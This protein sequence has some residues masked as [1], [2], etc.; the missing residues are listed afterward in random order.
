[1]WYRKN[2]GGWERA[3]RL[4]SEHLDHIVGDLDLARGGGG[5]VD[6]AA[7]LR[8]RLALT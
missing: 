7:V 3:A 6:V 2:V 8:E 5:A 1:M 4:M